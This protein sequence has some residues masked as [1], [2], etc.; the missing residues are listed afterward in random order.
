M[1]A[2]VHSITGTKVFPQFLHPFAHR[3][4]VTKISRLQ[5]FET[6]TNF[7]L[8]LFVSQGLQPFGQWLLTLF[9]LVSEDFNHGNNVAYKL[10]EGKSI[11]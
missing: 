1:A 9:G 2:K 6:D 4:T 8:C 10:R 7:G 11:E 3:T 5:A